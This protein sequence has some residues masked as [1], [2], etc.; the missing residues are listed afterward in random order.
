M[1]DPIPTPYELNAYVDGEL[2]PA[3]HGAFEARIAADPALQAQLEELRAFRPLLEAS[4]APEAAGVSDADFDRILGQVEKEIAPPARRAPAPTTQSEG[5]QV[6]SAGSR[7]RR[8]ARTASV[9]MGLAAMAAAFALY[10]NSGATT[11]ADRGSD[12]GPSTA[13]AAKVAPNAVPAPDRGEP[14]PQLAVDMP[15]RAKAG[16]PSPLDVPESNEAE[17]ERIEF[18]GNT[19]RISRIEG[20]RGTTTVIWIEEDEAPV[21]SERSL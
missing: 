14:S 6:I 5:A 17:I 2:E 16:G 18:G 12:P 7:F 1:T 8:F 13:E 9:P 21:E 10:I 20:V 3:A 4:L 19:G 11:V 15:S